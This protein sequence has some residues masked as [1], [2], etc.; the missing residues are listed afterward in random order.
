MAR[1][2]PP[3]DLHEHVAFDDPDEARTRVFDVTYLTSSWHCIFGQG[4]PGVLDAPA[5]ELVQGCCSYGAHFV[6]DDDHQRT[7]TGLS[8]YARIIFHEWL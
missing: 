8:V 5:P 2:R 7:D 6:N 4:C 3:Q 1:R